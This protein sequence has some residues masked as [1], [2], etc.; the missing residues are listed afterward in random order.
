MTTRPCRAARARWAVSLFALAAATARA[1]GGPPRTPPAVPGPPAPLYLQAADLA[2]GVLVE[3]GRPDAGASASAATAPA[4]APT[5]EAG[6]TQQ[7]DGP[8]GWAAAADP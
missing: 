2:P 8:A 5:G 6:R 4:T 7:G 1:A 3:W